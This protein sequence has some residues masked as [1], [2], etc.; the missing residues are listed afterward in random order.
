MSAERSPP[1]QAEA[2]LALIGPYAFAFAAS[3]VLTIAESAPVVPVPHA[4]AWMG[5]VTRVSASLWA[6]VDLGR[7]LGVSTVAPGPL[8]LPRVPC[9]AAW[10]VR[11]HEIQPCALAEPGDGWQASTP[12]DLGP[13][14][15]RSLDQSL[16]ARP[17]PRFALGPRDLLLPDGTRVRAEGLSLERLLAHPRLREIRS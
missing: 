1:A 7:F 12:D 4:P 15:N 14:S 11:V 13:D 6:V 5:G 2:W 17:R 16:I 10:A 9:G 8:L 3:E